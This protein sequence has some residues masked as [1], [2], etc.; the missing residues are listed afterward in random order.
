MDVFE[1][2]GA[3]EGSANFQAASIPQPLEP[4]QSPGSSP[5]SS[6]L[7]DDQDADDIQVLDPAGHASI[8]SRLACPICGEAVSEEVRDDFEY[9]YRKGNLLNYKWQHRFC[10]YHRRHDA[11]LLWRT[12]GFP[13]IDWD[14]FGGR[15]RKSKHRNH[16]KRIINGDSVSVYRQ[17]M[18]R[19]LKTRNKTALETMEGRKSGTSAGYYGPRGEK[20]M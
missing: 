20:L 15:L 18:E 16:V 6:L 4:G 17:R 14:R 12:K 3:Q 11:K 9:E 1:F 10:L 5:L 19:N 13:D 7:S 8:A 2:T